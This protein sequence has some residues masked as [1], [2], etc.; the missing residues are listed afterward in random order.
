MPT[1]TRPLIAVRLVGPADTVTAQRD[2]LVAHFTLV[3]G[4]GAIC[5]ASIR[6]ANH[7]DERRVYLTVTA[8]EVPPR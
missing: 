5:R 1:R 7:A 6:H 2:Q 3:F 8:K 4:P